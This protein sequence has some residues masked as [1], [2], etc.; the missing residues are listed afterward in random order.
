MISL[1]IGLCSNSAMASNTHYQRSLNAIRTYIVAQKDAVISAAEAKKIAEQRFGGKALSA[2]L[3]KYDN[4]N[5]VYRVKMINGGRVKVV[6]IPAN[7]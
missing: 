7:P 5:S 1:T 4:G 2:T 6:T 3:E